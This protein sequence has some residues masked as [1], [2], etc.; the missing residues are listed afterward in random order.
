[1]TQLK[2][3]VIE[4]GQFF[5]SR[6]FLKQAAV[7]ESALEAELMKTRPE[8]FPVQI[9]EVKTQEELD[10]QIVEVPPCAA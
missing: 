9:S 5:P 3:F 10:G 2:D 4:W 6:E 8:I 1:M 7:S